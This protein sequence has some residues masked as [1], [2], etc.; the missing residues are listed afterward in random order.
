MYLSIIIGDKSVDYFDEF[1]KQWNSIG[2]E[3]LL[4]EVKEVVQ[5]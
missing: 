4:S 5:N 1:V 3:T 2:G